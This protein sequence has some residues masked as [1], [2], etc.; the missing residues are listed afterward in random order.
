[1]HLR[2]KVNECD[3][4]EVNTLLKELELISGFRISEA[5]NYTILDFFQQVLKPNGYEKNPI[6]I[7]K[8]DIDEYDPTDEFILRKKIGKV[9]D[10]I[11]YI[12]SELASVRRYSIDDFTGTS[13]YVFLNKHIY[14]TK[15]K[16]PPIIHHKCK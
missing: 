2:K 15:K 13:V 3:D 10:G 8:A 4:A 11:F 5:R 7:S 1:M 6:K 16:N 14:G 9:G 12:C